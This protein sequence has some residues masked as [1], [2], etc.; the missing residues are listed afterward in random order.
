VLGTELP[1]ASLFQS[2]TVEQLAQTIRQAGALLGWSALVPIQPGGSQAPLFCVHG[3]GGGVLGYA[4]LARL[5]GPEQP[6]YGLQAR[7]LEGG[8]PP[9]PRVEDMAIRYVEAMRS[10]RPRGPYCLGGYSF[11]GVVA[12][13]MARLLQTQGEQVALLALFDAYAPLMPDVRSQLWHPRVLISFLRNLP[14]WVRDLWRRQGGVRQLLARIRVLA[15][16]A[17]LRRTRDT[18]PVR[19]EAA[20]LNVLGDIGEE[21]RGLMVAH[22]RALESYRPQV[23]PGHATL[24][25]VRGMRLLRTYDADLGW[26]Q[27]ATGGVEVQMIPGAHYNILEKPYVNVLAAQLRASLARAH[28]ALQDDRPQLD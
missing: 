27:L 5:L 20:V 1:V 3:V 23:C 28:G 24:F 11:G 15:R 9:D 17:W 25:R 8:E 6:V 10:V 21:R 4:E 13:E 16:T 19:T 2:P 14:Y 12:F 26:G 7:G 18:D 22:L